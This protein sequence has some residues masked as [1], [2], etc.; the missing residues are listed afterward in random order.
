MSVLLGIG[1]FVVLY[2]PMYE[3]EYG[4]LYGVVNRVI[5]VVNRGLFGFAALVV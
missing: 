5:L 2:C 4:L 3:V 1:R